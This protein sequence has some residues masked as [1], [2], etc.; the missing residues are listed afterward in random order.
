MSHTKLLLKEDSN[1]SFG[2]NIFWQ[3]W[4]KEEKYIIVTSLYSF[5][6]KLITMLIY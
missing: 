5:V 6:I 4:L 3:L 2:E 1:I